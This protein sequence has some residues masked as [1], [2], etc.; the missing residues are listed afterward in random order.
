ME[1]DDFK[2]YVDMAL[3]LLLQRCN[4]DSAPI[5]MPVGGVLEQLK[6][7][8]ESK[9]YRDHLSGLSQAQAEN[10]QRAR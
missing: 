9:P 6:S 4:Q 1:K 8:A 7:H 5:Y 10:Y 3:H 2:Q